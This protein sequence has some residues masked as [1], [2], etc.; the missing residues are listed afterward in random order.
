MKLVVG[1]RPVL[2]SLMGMVA[3]TGLNQ[4]SL[5]NAL[6]F[7]RPKKHALGLAEPLT[8][9]PESVT[10]SAA[11]P[12]WQSVAL[13]ASQSGTFTAEMDAT[14]LGANIDAGVGLSKSATASVT[15]L[16]CMAR[17]NSSGRI[18]ARNGGVFGAASAI[19][20]TA[21]TSYRFRFSVNIPAHTYSVYVTPA[22]RS[23]QLLGQNFAFRTDQSAVTSLDT[24]SLFANTGAMRGCGF[25]A[26][27]Y[28]AWAGSTW[29]NKSFAAQS[30]TFGVEFDAT[31]SAAG[32]D[33]VVGL[34]NGAQTT[35]SGFAC[36]VRFNPSPG[37]I[38]AI[39]GGGYQAVS[40]VPYAA[41]TIYHFRL[42]ADIVSH[43]YSIYVTPAGG[44]EQLIGRDF[45]FRTQQAAVTRLNNQG[46]KID[47]ATGSLR[48]C[49]FT[50]NAGLDDFEILMLNPTVAG[51]RVWLSNW[52]ERPSRALYFGPDPQDPEFRIRG[53]GVNYVIDDQG[54]LK[55]TT[56]QGF[57][58]QNA[59][60]MYVYDQSFRDT[61]TYDPARYLTW[62]NVEVTFYAM[63]RTDQNVGYAGLVAGAKIRHIPDTDLCGDRGYYGKMRNDGRMAFEKEIYH[64]DNTNGYVSVFRESVQDQRLWPTPPKDVWIGYKFIARDVDSGR[65]VKLELW[66]DM[67]DGANGGRWEKLHEYVDVGGWGSGARPCAPDIDPT[68][69]LA[70]PNLSVFIR[71][72][73]VGEWRYKKFSIREIAAA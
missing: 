31:P 49:N 26:G 40:A 18:D 53:E 47:S 4:S 16:A 67:T 69:I 36:L 30:A 61:D 38:D 54:I 19:P 21:N 20:Y 32:I 65:H 46:V 5:L 66:R 25:G 9:L 15:G 68:M 63:R 24:W 44:S 60:R 17:F 39:N 73:G 57:T 51:G 3:A 22:G 48:L 71:N 12:R 29:I 34:S 27:C 10:V 59:L 58:G 52:K 50:V 7:P 35:F 41:N 70:G 33:A 28:S 45:A 72:D 8:T 43:T 64:H 42:L 23:E 56:V 37:T 2:H 55:A 1:R 11:G 14:P 6:S 62:N 13:Q